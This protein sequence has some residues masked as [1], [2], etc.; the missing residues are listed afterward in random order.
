LASAQKISAFIPRLGDIADLMTGFAAGFPR[1]IDF[2]SKSA[3][4]PA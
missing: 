2:Q 3:S 4:N 1:W